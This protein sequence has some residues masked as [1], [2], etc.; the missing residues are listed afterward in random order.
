[1]RERHWVHRLCQLIKAEKAALLA[2]LERAE[3]AF[4]IIEDRFAAVNS[5][6]QKKC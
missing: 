1:L 3:A 5:G 6:L 4:R 2:G